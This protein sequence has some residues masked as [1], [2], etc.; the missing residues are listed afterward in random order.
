MSFCKRH[1]KEKSRSNIVRTTTAGSSKAKLCMDFSK[2]IKWKGRTEPIKLK[3]TEKTKVQ[4]M[5][6]NMFDIFPI[7]LPLFYPQKQNEQE[8]L[9][10]S[11]MCIT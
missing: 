1:T 10:I 5:N 9:I 11:W 7:F 3:P 8:N 2:S 4:S 6:S